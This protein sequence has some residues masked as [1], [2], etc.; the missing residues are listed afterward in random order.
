MSG[1][2]KKMHDDP[3]VLAITDRQS[4]QVGLAAVLT[5]ILAMRSSLS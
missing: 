1:A 2:R 5:L 3:V 4:Y